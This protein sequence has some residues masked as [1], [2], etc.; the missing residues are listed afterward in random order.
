MK[1]AWLSWKLSRDPHLYKYPNNLL[2]REFLS[3]QI[4]TWASRTLKP[5]LEGVQKQY[6][7]VLTR[8]CPA[9]SFFPSH[10]PKDRDI[11]TLRN[12]SGR[13]YPSRREREQYLVTGEGVFFFERSHEPQ[14]A[15]S[16]PEHPA[17]EPSDEGRRSRWNF[18]TSWK[19]S[20][21]RCVY[22]RNVSTKVS[23]G[24]KLILHGRKYRL[25]F[26]CPRLLVPLFSHVSKK[27]RV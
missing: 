25:R 9:Y 27:T 3:E 16:R 26:R 13:N 22:V 18:S 10:R 11:T 4:G 8:L 7:A 15:I 23:H 6:A 17:R 5:R 1:T 24:R 14:K 21:T 12:H 2:I 19:R 20:S